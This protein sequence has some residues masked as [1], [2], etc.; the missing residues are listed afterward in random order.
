MV[1]PA[2]R[3][4]AMRNDE[5]RGAYPHVGI[6]DIDPADLDVVE[7]AADDRDQFKIVRVD[8]STADTWKV[9]VACASARILESLL[10]HFG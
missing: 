1:V 6:I 9:T 4:T 3:I 10:D 7:R 2:I 8:R 5:V